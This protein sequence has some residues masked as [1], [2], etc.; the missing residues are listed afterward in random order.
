LLFSQKKT[1]KMT[2]PPAFF[3]ALIPD[4]N[5]MGNFFLTTAKLVSLATKDFL[6]SI[7]PI[8]SQINESTW[9]PAKKI[10]L[11]EKW[12]S[13]QWEVGKP[14]TRII[15]IEAYGLRTDQL[16]DLSI[17]KLPG[18]NLYVDPP[19]RSNRILNNMIIGVLEK[20]ITYIPNQAKKWI[21][22]AIKLNWWE[23][24]THKK[25]ISQLNELSIIATGTIYSFNHSNE[26][27]LT[28]PLRQLSKSFIKTKTKKDEK[29][30]KFF[31]FLCLGIVVFVCILIGIIWL[32]RLTKSTKKIY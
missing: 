8:P 21:I 14:I 7:L 12:S 19:K 16:P 29:L 26:K 23:I 31:V 15:K 24:S 28:L 32:L 30:S 27:L 2:I 20:K 18:M 10:L 9:L 4:N 11:T 13:P 25:K 22:P 3:K 17:Q 1:G 5:L 6:L